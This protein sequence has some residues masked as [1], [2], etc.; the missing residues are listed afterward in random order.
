MSTVTLTIDGRQVQAEAGSSILQ[1]AQQAGIHIPTLCYHPDLT[2]RAVC[3][4][5]VVEVK[6]ARTL[7]A[8]CSYPVTEGLVVTTNSPRIRASRKVNL[9][10][11]LSNHPFNCPTCV[12]N[13]NCELRALANEYNITQ[14]RFEGERKEYLI[15]SSSYSLVRD[16][17]KCILCRRCV[18]VCNSVQA[19]GA[20]GPVHRGFDTVIG[21]AYDAK[22]SEVAC[23]MCGQCINR[24]PV[25]ALYEK[26]A[27]DDVWEAL[28][29]GSKQ[30]AVQVAPA[31]RV[32]LG[33]EFGMEPGQIV[34]GKLAAALRR[35][36]FDAVFDTNFSADLTIMEEGYELIDRIQNGGVLP[37]MTSCSPGWIKYI[38]HF[39]PE[40]LPNLSSCKSP[41]QM[42]GALIKSYYAEKRG[43]D[44]ANIV[45]VSVMPCTAKKFECERPEMTDSGFKDVD[46]VLTTRE[47]AKMIREAGIEFNA[48]PEEGFDSP[49][50]A[51]TGAAVIFGATGGV[52][53]ASLRTAYEV[54]TGTELKKLDFE[55]VRGMEG[56]KQATVA[57]GD[58]PVKV[59]VAHGLSNAKALMEKV[60]A[61]EADYHFIEIMCCPGG[62]I[63]G[64]GQPVPTTP[65]IRKKRAE[66]IYREDR[67]LPLRKSHENPE[68]QE[69][70]RE[71]LVKPLG[72][73]SHHLL[74]T[75]YTPRPR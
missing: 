50:G 47:L 19:V 64:G 63:G 7:Q 5:C 25:G 13:Q 21:P 32:A 6:N 70:Y 26:D 12:R 54:L 2:V 56:I 74:H 11:L 18:D 42:M 72:E 53:E 39:Y 49:L 20:I 48:L 55:S 44:P 10:L 71:F 41:Q 52:I 66:A 46:Y 57:V 38:E 35:L 23:A 8:A 17:N 14:V 34:T 73:K 36:G 65:E 22:L 43:I 1:A 61:G 4:I 51:G 75:H 37:Q 45:S 60:K 69:I 33:E 62:C 29:D 59:A 24:C 40:L 68:V 27:I 30:V 15:D 9:E 67:G 31:V 58:L 3:R 28:A 16:P